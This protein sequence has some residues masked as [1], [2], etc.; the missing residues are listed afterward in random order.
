MVNFI[1]I[2]LTY[3]IKMRRNKSTHCYNT[4][5]TIIILKDIKHNLLYN[6][7][8]SKI[9][10]MLM[11]IFLAKILLYLIKQIKARISYS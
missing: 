9:K 10:L 2:G 11:L 4:P 8:S 6:N 1:R 7:N 5:T 3:A